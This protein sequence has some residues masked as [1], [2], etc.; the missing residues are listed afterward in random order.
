MARLA[1]CRN[2]YQIPPQNE[3]DAT[4]KTRKDDPKSCQLF[5]LDCAERNEGQCEI[6][7]SHHARELSPIMENHVIENEALELED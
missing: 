5:G 2:S 4:F 7:R 1:L 3:A 6:Q